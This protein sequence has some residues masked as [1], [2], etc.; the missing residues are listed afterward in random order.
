VSVDYSADLMLL[1]VH[2]TEMI[3]FRGRFLGKKKKLC[4]RMSLKNTNPKIVQ[5]NK[6]AGVTVFWLPVWVGCSPEYWTNAECLF[7]LLLAPHAIF[8]K[9]QHTKTTWKQTIILFINSQSSSPKNRA[10]H[11]VHRTNKAAT[12]ACIHSVFLDYLAHVR[13]PDWAEPFFG[14]L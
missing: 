7:G 3:Q 6:Y 13:A 2:T 10:H 4:S 8:S 5:P 11:T 12:S 9:T 1:F 14:S